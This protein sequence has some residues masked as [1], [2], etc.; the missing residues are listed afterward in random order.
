MLKG[1]TINLALNPFGARQLRPMESVA[2]AHLELRNGVRTDGGNYV[3]RP[4]YATKWDAG[5]LQP[6][7]LLMPH[8]RF[9]G[10]SGFAVME[11]GTIYQ[12]NDDETVTLLTGPTLNGVFRP[13]WCQFDT[14]VIVCDG[15]APV[16]IPPSGTT[17]DLLA[18][19]PP[20]AKYC[21]VIAERVILSGYN[22]TEFQWSDPGS[23]TT[24]PGAANISNVT[25]HGE[26][27]RFMQIAGT[28][29]YFFKTASIEIWSHIGG[30]EVFG[31]RGIIPLM[32]KFSKN[33]GIAS[34]SVVMAGDPPA[35]L[36]YCDGDFQTLQGFTPKRISGSYKREIG[37]L[38]TT[39]DCYGFDFTKEH[40]VRWYFPT[41]G[42]CFVYDYV[43]Q[44][45]TE[46]NGWAQGAFTRMPI[47][48]YMELDGVGYVGDYNPTGR[49]ST[50]SDRLYSDNGTE[51]RL[52]RSLR[53]PL[54]QFG[55]QTRVNR[56]RLRL[57]RGTV[58]AT[59]DPRLS[60]RWAF[61]EGP[62]SSYVD[63]SLGAVGQ[64]NPYVDVKARTQTLGV[65]KEIKVE[66][67]QTAPAPHLL[68]NLNL[69]TKDLGR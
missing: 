18:G 21:A 61:D 46:D 20:A 54:S 34:F 5:V 23:S 53:H 27:I 42:R 59:P 1:H 69:T 12:L 55:H 58:D 43:N 49:I 56:M 31:R 63:V 33:R 57:E 65:G 35:F 32:D 52:L 25:G 2:P 13:T 39:E 37:A 60:V 4:G 64:R 36:F 16:A 68:T 7:T 8:R 15:Q 3:M 41:E 9:P 66:M 62:W 26:E 19:N 45:M 11:D 17:V 48:S 47:Y 29:L 40:V 24:W 14:D 67:V 10:S 51:I 22:D 30:I 44:V 38:Q 28:D 6:V 50:W